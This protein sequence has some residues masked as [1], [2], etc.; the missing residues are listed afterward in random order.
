[1]TKLVSID[2]DGWATWSD[3]CRT[4][5]KMPEEFKDPPK[6]PE[7]LTVG[8][9]GITTKEQFEKLKDTNP[10]AYEAIKKQHG[11][12]DVWGNDKGFFYAPFI[13]EMVCTRFSEVGYGTITV[14]GDK[15]ETPK[16]A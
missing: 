16:S 11:E 8:Y 3:G 5:L 1:M 9:K 13:P 12:W 10:Q 4:M 6:P 15:D 7:S 2:E 14:V